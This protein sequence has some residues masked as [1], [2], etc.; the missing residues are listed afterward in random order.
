MLTR[1]PSAPLQPFVRRLWATEAAD[2]AVRQVAPRERVLPTGGLHVAFLLGD[3]LRLFRD[4]DDQEGQVIGQA[5]VGGARATYYVRDVSRPSLSVGAAL[6]PG[7][8]ELFLGVPAGEIAGIHTPLE[9]LWGREA[10]LALERIADADSPSARLDRLEALLFARLPRV[11]R[12]HPAVAQALARFAISP[13]API[14]ELVEATGYSHRH[15]VTVF[16]DAVGLPPKIY[17][18]VLR[19]QQAI[20]RFALRPAPRALEVALDAGYADQSHL[21]RDFRELGGISPDRY[22]RTAPVW[23]NHVPLRP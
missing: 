15:F 23:S 9:D 11:R 8:A 7:V 16:R 12:V 4:D 22:R 21:N 3:P 18:R 20:G 1:L 17:A 2:A 10:R 19:F 5:V 13:A 14:R 6:Q